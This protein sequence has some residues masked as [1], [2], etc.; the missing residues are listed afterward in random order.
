MGVPVTEGGTC[1]P[2]VRC[3]SEDL[4]FRAE[5]LRGA[6]REECLV[7]ERRCEMDLLG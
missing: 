7:G 6:R 4:G 3:E 2:L 1:V 5:A